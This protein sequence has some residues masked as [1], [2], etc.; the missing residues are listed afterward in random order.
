ML[1]PKFSAL[2]SC[3]YHL[4]RGLTIPL[5]R[6]LKPSPSWINV[7]DTKLSKL[8][9]FVLAHFPFSSR[10]AWFVAIV[11]KEKKD[12]MSWRVW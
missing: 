6:R 11:G 12:Y 1:K 8:D 9:N 2:T 5:C 4:Y 10:F 3:E 7:L